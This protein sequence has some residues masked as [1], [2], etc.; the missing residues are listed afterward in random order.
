MNVKTFLNRVF[1]LAG[2]PDSFGDG[3]WTQEEVTGFTNDIAKEIAEETLYLVETYIVPAVAEQIDYD[4]PD[5]HID[6]VLKA[7][8]YKESTSNKYLLDVQDQSD[9]HD[10][11]EEIVNPIS[12]PFQVVKTSAKTFSVCPPPSDGATTLTSGTLTVGVTY[13]ITGF[14]T[15]DDFTNVGAASNADDVEFVAT[16]TTPTTWTN[17]SEVT[18]IDATVFEFDHYVYP[19]DI[20]HTSLTTEIDFPKG[21]INVLIYLVVAEMLLSSEDEKVA[22]K[23]GRYLSRGT[24][25]LA[26]MKNRVRAKRTGDSNKGGSWIPNRK[27]ITSDVHE[28]INRA[29]PAS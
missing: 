1:N 24:N 16:G 15:G 19:D 22:A 29:G 18:Q 26:F 8:Y 10:G 17:S 7:F 28:A 2:A 12:I 3:N 25:K 4:L 14:V 11:R 20:S 21:H 9:E 5:N 6:F 27:H 23:G 13:R